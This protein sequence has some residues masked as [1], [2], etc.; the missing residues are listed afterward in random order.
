MFV[1]L[2]YIFLS[3]GFTRTAWNLTWQKQQSHHKLVPSRYIYSFACNIIQ[4]QTGGRRVSSTEPVWAESLPGRR[5]VL[6]EE[7]MKPVRE[8]GAGEAGPDDSSE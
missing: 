5:R 6:L 7:G 1:F 4:V 8:P 3:I 2:Q